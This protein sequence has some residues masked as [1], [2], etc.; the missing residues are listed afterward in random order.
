MNILWTD[1]LQKTWSVESSTV[2]ADLLPLVGSSGVSDIRV[3]GS[4]ICWIAVSIVVEVGLD[5]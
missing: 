4:K 1:A 2:S 5:S 3:L